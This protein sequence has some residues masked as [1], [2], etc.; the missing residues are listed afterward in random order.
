M[1]P[2]AFRGPEIGIENHLNYI[3]RPGGTLSEDEAW[4]LAALYNSRLLDTWFRVV[5]G[6]TQVSATELRTMPHP[7]HGVIVALGRRVKG[8]DA[9]T[10]GLDALVMDL[11]A[12]PGPAEAAIGGR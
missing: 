9:P 3:H 5:N 2:R 8:L 6:N 10:D 1:Q 11:V 4:G 12:R 7:P